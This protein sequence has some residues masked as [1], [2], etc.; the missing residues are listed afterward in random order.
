MNNNIQES[1]DNS[2]SEDE[3]IQLPDGFEEAFIGIARQFGKPFGVY[4]RKK[5]IDILVERDGMSYEEADEYF[6]YNVEGAWVGENTPAFLE[7]NE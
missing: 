7:R 3:T 6:A 2:L 1:I 5:C 4:D